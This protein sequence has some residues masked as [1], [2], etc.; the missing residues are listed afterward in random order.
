M[1]RHGFKKM[2]TFTHNKRKAKTTQIGKTC[3]GGFW[4]VDY[5]LFLEL[6]VRYRMD[7]I[8]EDY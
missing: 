5:V 4:A 7:L 3:K 6:R 1:K 8:C 2:V